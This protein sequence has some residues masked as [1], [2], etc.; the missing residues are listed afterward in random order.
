MSTSSKEVRVNADLEPLS[1]AP[2]HPLPSKVIHSLQTKAA[3]SNV[4]N[5]NAQMIAGADN[6]TVFHLL[7]NANRAAHMHENAPAHGA[8]APAQQNTSTSDTCDQHQQLQPGFHVQVSAAASSYMECSLRLTPPPIQ[9][10]RLAAQREQPAPGGNL[11]TSHTNVT[12]LLTGQTD[13]ST[14][15]PKAPSM[16]IAHN[17]TLSS[18]AGSLSRVNDT[19]DTSSSAQSWEDFL[20]DEA[21]YVEKGNWAQFPPNSRLFLGNIPCDRISKHEM[22]DLFSEY[23]RLVQISKHEMYA[24]VQYC[25]PEDCQAAIAGL[26]GFHVG[27][28]RVYVELARSKKSGRAEQGRASHRQHSD[29]HRPNKRR[30]SKRSHPYDNAYQARRADRQ[31]ADEQQRDHASVRHGKGPAR[32]PYGHSDSRKRSRSPSPPWCAHGARD[33]RERSRSPNPLRDAHEARDGRER[34]RSPSPPRDAHEAR[35]GRERSR[36]PNPPRDAHGAGDGDHNHAGSIGT[37]TV[38][39]VPAQQDLPRQPVCD[40][41]VFVQE[42]SVREKFVRTVERNF[43]ER[44]LT[45]NVAPEGSWDGRDAEIQRLIVDGINAVIEIDGRAQIRHQVPMTIF[46][47]SRGIM[48]VISKR[49]ENLNPMVAAHLLVKATSI[50]APNGTLYHPTATMAPSPPY[51][52]EGEEYGPW[53]WHIAYARPRTV[54]PGRRNGEPVHSQHPTVERDAPNISVPQITPEHFQTLLGTTSG[55]RPE[56]GYSPVPD[57]SSDEMNE[58]NE[59]IGDPMDI[60]GPSYL[61]EE[62][63]DDHSQ[64]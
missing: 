34:S 40:V 63:N 11:T 64:Q 23:G 3:G 45:V 48:N 53:R 13:H 24:F 14:W 47:R 22:F 20:V 33:G 4:I 27:S 56:P 50:R 12:P 7:N 39:P 5:D 58:M 30:Y 36:S 18:S 29:D 57:A 38:A 60:D 62:T 26:D 31:Q 55:D 44:G 43:V 21:E 1:P 46:D 35:D 16:G 10:S 28:Q 25:T 52:E 41:Q 32:V 6:L 8:R 49:Y 59:S 2:T 42:G 51:C 15:P 17:S 9:P 54:T 19:H 37:S 61:L